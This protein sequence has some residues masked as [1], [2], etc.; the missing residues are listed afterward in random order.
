M[1]VNRKLAA[2][3]A[4]LFG[5]VLTAWTASSF[6]NPTNGSV[7]SGDAQISSGGNTVTINQTSQN[8]SINW[9]AF[10]IKA[11]ES[12]AFVQPNASSLTVN[13][14]TGGD[15]SQ[16]LGTLTANGHIFLIN[17]NGVLFGS[18]AV[19][20]TAGLVATTLNISDADIAAGHYQFSGTAGDVVNAGQLTASSGGYV[21]LMGGH[22]NNTGTISTPGGTSALLAGSNIT[23]ALQP[24]SPL[25]YTINTG[26]LNALVENHGAVITDGGNIILAAKDAD[27]LANAV[28]NIDGLLQASTLNQQGGSI[29]AS[30]DILNAYNTGPLQVSGVANAFNA[31]IE[32]RAVTISSGATLDV[33][34]IITSNNGN[35]SLNSGTLST[36]TGNTLTSGT[37]D[38]GT[39]ITYSGVMSG[40]GGFIKAG[41]GTLVLSS[42]T[43]SNAGSTTITGSNTI[44]AGTL[45]G[46][47]TSSAGVIGATSCATCSST[48]GPVAG[49]IASSAGAIT[50][51]TGTISV[52]NSSTQ[53]ANWQA[54]NIS[55]EASVKFEQSSTS[56][57][58]LNRVLG[59]KERIVGDLSAS[60]QAFLVNSN[61][62]VDAARVSVAGVA[63]A[64]PAAVSVPSVGAVSAQAATN[65]THG[66]SDQ[67][68][69]EV[70]DAAAVSAF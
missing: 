17:P 15:A 33:N 10:G 53:V 49:T 3:L 14:V 24:G 42:V 31:W 19:V 45:G 8:A 46:S 13:R 9:Q 60:G 18:S 34:N 57:V 51:N 59:E 20:N 12:V 58:A 30:A 11:G 25:T 41:T 6:A 43:S 70:I 26:T 48:S 7:V 61:G 35:I 37:V 66:M 64:P 5:V 21:V 23:L 16:I 39:S 63:S 29:V 4:P 52:Q 67:S 50:L 22:V 28:V 32:S 68:L 54:F 40:T 56:S 62:V 44:S 1:K 36:S 65:A 55:K 47:N 38:L 69:H 2:A 27:G